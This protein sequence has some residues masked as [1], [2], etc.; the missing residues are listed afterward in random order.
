MIC[1]K[2]LTAE[3]ELITTK[4][5]VE[6]QESYQRIAQW[7]HCFINFVNEVL[8]YGIRDCEKIW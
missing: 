4:A 8:M 3:V 6:H 2:R 1:E 5:V 7:L